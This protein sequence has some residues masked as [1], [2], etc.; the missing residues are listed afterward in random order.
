MPH[1]RVCARPDLPSAV[2]CG[3]SG[4][5]RGSSACS[6]CMHFYLVRRSLRATVSRPRSVC[7]FL[8]VR[9]SARSLCSGPAASRCA[10]LGAWLTLMPMPAVAAQWGWSHLPNGSTHGAQRTGTS[11]HLRTTL[12]Y[13]PGGPVCRLG[14]RLTLLR[15][16]LPQEHGVFASVVFCTPLLVIATTIMILSLRSTVNMMVVT[17]RLEL[18]HSLR[19]QEQQQ[20]KASEG[21]A[22]QRQCDGA[23]SAAH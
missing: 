10:C 1:V 22:Q 17:K 12:T 13:A 18:Q 4:Q 6:L 16:L 20:R 11:S 21:E 23:Y 2:A 9:S 8:H 19:A 7:S 15:R 14:L 3:G 5:S